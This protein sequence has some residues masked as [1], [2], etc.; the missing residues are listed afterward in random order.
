MRQM[1]DIHPLEEVD[2][3]IAPEP[4]VQ[5]AMTHIH[6]YD[7]CRSSLQETVGKSAGSRPDVDAD[8]VPD[9]DTKGVEGTLKLDTA[10]ADEWMFRT[11]DGDRRTGSDQGPRL[12]DPLTIYSHPAG[13]DHSPC[14][15][16][17]LDQLL[18]YK[19]LI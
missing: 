17:A 3:G 13:K 16:S 9:R 12:I 19:A 10:P 8:L 11:D 18:F 7:P 15:L 2:A 6:G 1:P 4:L 5:V 14:T